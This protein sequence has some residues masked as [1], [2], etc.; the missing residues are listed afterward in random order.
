MTDGESVDKIFSNKGKDDRRS[1]FVKFI[2]EKR[3]GFAD[4]TGVLDSGLSRS[5]WDSY[6]RGRGIPKTKKT[7]EAVARL[8]NV[9]VGEFINVLYPGF[10]S[11]DEISNYKKERARERCRVNMERWRNDPVKHSRLKE[12]S[13]KFRRAHRKPLD[14][15]TPLSIRARVNKALR[16]HYG[17][18][19]V[20]EFQD[21]LEN[22]AFRIKR[23]EALNTIRQMR[24]EMR[25]IRN[26]ITQM[27]RDLITKYTTKEYREEL[28]RKSW[29]VKSHERDSRINQLPGRLTRDQWLIILGVHQYK[30][31]YCGIDRKEARAKGF[32]LEIDH[33]IPITSELASNDP[34]NIAPACKSCNSSKSDKDLLEWAKATKRSIHPLVIRKYMDRTNQYATR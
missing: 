22:K 31:A 9:T 8:C 4:M 16:K 2:K 33:I 11:F 25:I 15:C 20:T 32:D 5:N 14:Q 23:Y 10:W 28:R 6:I 18:T 30:C 7:I 27:E 34:S 1:R 19:A 17:E 24:K 26:K 3:G 13:Q 29:Q 21:A 12:I